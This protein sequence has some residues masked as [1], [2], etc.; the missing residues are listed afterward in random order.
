MSAIEQGIF[1]AQTKKRIE[2]VEAAIATIQNRISEEKNKSPVSKE[3]LRD[4]L[5][6]FIGRQEFDQDII[7]TLV[8]N[9]LVFKDKVRITFN[10]SPKR[11]VPITEEELAEAKCSS[12]APQGSPRATNTNTMCFFY[13]DFWGIWCQK[14]YP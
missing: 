11:T 3:D 1:T 4:F 6:Q 7:D 14:S 9:V 10:Y 13:L 2:E 12:T 5:S 8:R